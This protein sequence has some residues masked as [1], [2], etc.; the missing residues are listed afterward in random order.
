MEQYSQY[1]DTIYDEQE[2]LGQIGRGTH[3]SVLRAVSWHAPNSSVLSKACQFD[4]SIIWD[5][6]H[7]RRVVR[8]V[9]EIYLNGLL[10]KFI[11]FG[12][13]KG[14]FTAVLSDQYCVDSGYDELVDCIER[15]A[16]NTA[17]D[18]CFSSEIVRLHDPLNSIIADTDEK[19][20]LYLSNLNMLWQLGSSPIPSLD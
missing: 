13:R 11:M 1:F 8:C 7:D 17:V 19:V 10:S 5:E 4:F 12:E 6:D 16:E 3:Y 18:D 9:E 2:P 15:I 20:R 14:M